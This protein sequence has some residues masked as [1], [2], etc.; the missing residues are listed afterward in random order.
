MSPNRS[1]SVLDYPERRT[2]LTCNTYKT[3]GDPL[4]RQLETSVVDAFDSSKHLSRVTSQHSLS[5]P[6]M[7]NDPMVLDDP[8]IPSP[9]VSLNDLTR[10][11]K[12]Q[13]E[14]IESLPPEA[15]FP[16]DSW[17]KFRGEFWGKPLVSLEM[18]ETVDRGEDPVEDDVLLEKPPSGSFPVIAAPKFTPTALGIASS[19]IVVRSEYDEAERAAILS[20]KS[21]VRLFVATGTPGIG[22]IPF[23]TVDHRQ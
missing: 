11:I 22:I 18:S 23:P 14:A 5:S 13:N 3:L 19:K 7:S 2:D 16:S 4:L 20:L 1:R 8:G 10:H 9:V 17:A 15:I 12:I 21:G 6:I